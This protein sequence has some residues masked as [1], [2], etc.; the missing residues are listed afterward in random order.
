MAKILTIKS[1]FNMRSIKALVEARVAAYINRVIDV[2][3]AAGVA[4]VEDARGRTKDLGSY[5]GGSFGNITWNLRSSIG[6]SVF[7]FGTSV[8]DY[9]PTLQSGAHGSKTGKEF[10]DEIYQT[11]LGDI[12]DRDSIVL[13][14][15]AGEHYARAVEARGYN[16][17]DATANIAEEI[18]LGFIQSA[19]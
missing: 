10:A 9:F 6:C 15:V 18:L 12:Y 4:M 1:K 19:A 13:I 2:Y 17:I 7:R 14:V 16:V 5:D 11:G 3:K 8:F